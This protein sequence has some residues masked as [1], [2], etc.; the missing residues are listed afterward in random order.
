MTRHAFR[1]QFT[2][3]L[4]MGDLQDSLMLARLACEALHGDAPVRLEASYTF[5]L[6]QRSCELAADSEV[7]RD[8]NRVFTG[9]ITK[10]FGPNSFR[11]EPI[12]AAPSRPHK[13][14]SSRHRTTKT[15]HQH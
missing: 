14:A 9:F 12:C 8:L 2:A 5:D 7:G 4:S 15:L 11:V 13:Q 6:R 1:Y 3:G 10:E